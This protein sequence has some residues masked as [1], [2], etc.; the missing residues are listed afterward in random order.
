VLLITNEIA[1]RLMH[2]TLV[3]CHQCNIVALVV[4][5][6]ALVLLVIAIIVVAVVAVVVVIVVVVAIKPHVPLFQQCLLS[7]TGIAMAQK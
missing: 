2:S 4:V 6:H 1:A 5:V 3:S 7:L